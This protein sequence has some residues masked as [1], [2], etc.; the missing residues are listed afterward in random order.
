MP[1]YSI[2]IPGKGT[3]RVESAKDL[4][5]QQAYQAVSSQLDME[6]MADPTSGMSTGEKL[7][8]GAGKAVSDLYLGAKE[9]L[10]FASPQDVEESR[11]LDAP[12]MN[13]GAGK[14]GNVLGNIGAFLPTMLIPGVNTYTGA[15]ATGAAFG[16][17]QP[18]TKNES[19]LSN[20]AIGGVSGLAGQA[21]GRGIGRVLQ[22]VQKGLSPEE[23]QL[24]AA[25]AK[26]GIP[27]TPGQATGSRPLQI[28]ESVMENLPFTAK[29][30]AAVR[31]AQ[32]RAFTAAAL[33][34]AGMS[35]NVA[36]G[37]ALLEQKLALG[38]QLGSIA[39]RNTLNFNAGLTD[40]LANIV[41]DAAK[42]LPPDSASKVAGTV[43]KILSQVD[44]SGS[45]LGT[46]Y[47]AWREPLRG[48][49][50][51]GTIG[52]YFGQIRKV[53]DQSF[54][55]QLT[56]SE[57]AAF[58]EASQKYANIKTIIDAMGGAGVLPAKGQIAPTQLAGAL[59]RSVGREGKALGR[60]DLNQLSKVGQVFVRDQIPNSGTAQREFIQRLLTSGGGVGGGAGIGAVGAAATGNDPMEGA[61]L[62]AGLT[63]GGLL[64]PRGIQMLMNS[65]GGR[66]YL[67][68][69][70]LSLSPQELAALTA[71]TRSGSVGLFSP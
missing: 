36:K 9:R 63:A 54:K 71:A 67:T 7:A 10:G 25:A 19:V 15:A 1:V 61:L 14:V 50:S 70:L 60:G 28:T 39:E 8:A 51:D 6:R 65:P 69:G 44:E 20:T 56:G 26:E 45:M 35:G 16:A 40:K 17:L 55:S 64:A 18:T 49:S 22:P 48:L 27:L 57:A 23:Q 46:N 31:E 4:T 2:D 58:N 53:L 59:G 29:P 52:H 47:Q 43:D 33:K 68:K 21:I 30:Q 12:L 37:G 13:T 62:G 11:K 3:F 41:D 66:A 38:G 32:Q 42:H 5:P 24:A 34:R